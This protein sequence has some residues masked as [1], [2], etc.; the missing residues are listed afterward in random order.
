MLFLVVIPSLNEG[1]LI[2][3]IW[4]KRESNVDQ[5]EQ[6]TASLSET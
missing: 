6:P 2:A 4:E 5:T 3:W 1:G